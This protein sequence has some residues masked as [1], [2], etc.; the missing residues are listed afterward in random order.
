ML[1]LTKIE[2]KLQQDATNCYVCGKRI[3][4]FNKSKNHGK[5]RDH[6]HYTSKYR[7]KAHSICNF[8]LN[9]PNKSS[10]YDH[11]FIIKRKKKM[12]LRD[13]LNVLAKVDKT[14]KLFPFQYKMKLEKLIIMPMKML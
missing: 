9:V 10:S 4:F 3:L 7:G 14:S 2:L 13:N 11:H 5:V 12:S 1:P 6:C 8:K